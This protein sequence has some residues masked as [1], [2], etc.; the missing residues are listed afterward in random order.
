MNDSLLPKVNIL[1]SSYN[2]E[3]F[4]EEQLISLLSQD[5]GNIEIYVRDDGSEDNT[6]RLLKGY[7]DQIHVDYGEN[8]GFIG[9]FLSLLK[10]C[11]DAEYY[12]FCDQDDVWQEEKISRAVEIL[13]RA[14]KKYGK[15][16]PILYFS[17]YNFTDENLNVTGR[18]KTPSNIS[19]ANC[20]MDC[21]PLGFVTVFNK[22]AR[23]EIAAAIPLK[24]CGH[25]WWAYMV[26]CGL[27]K[28][29]YDDTVTVNYRR[30]G[31]NVSSGGA[32]F[33][34]FMIWRFKKFFA[35][36]YFLNITEQLREY[37]ELYSNRLSEE[38]RQILSLFTEKSL[39]N[40]VKKVF[41]PHKFRQN[42]TDELFLRCCFLLGRL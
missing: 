31:G 41:Y 8:K 33:F 24:S 9:S 40:T 10:S 34:Q 20:L 16:L 17:A 37:E 18:S 39:K 42:I 23:E 35:N 27:G 13:Q 5:Y 3:R 22:S 19:F 28:V 6:K 7:E 26:C 4:V 1:L 11:E 25:D 15:G 32:G 30:C 14:E 38:N 2:G 21:A 36:S 12:A 29:I